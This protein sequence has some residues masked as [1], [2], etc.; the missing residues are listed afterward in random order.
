M[1]PVMFVLHRLIGI[2][3]VASK[4]VSIES[5]FERNQRSLRSKQMFQ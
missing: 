5:S 3:S 2:E 1:F 4:V